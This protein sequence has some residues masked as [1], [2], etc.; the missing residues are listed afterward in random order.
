ME[1]GIANETE[2][3]TENANA[4]VTVTVTVTGIENVTATV[5][6]TAIRA[7]TTNATGTANVKETVLTVTVI[8]TA[9]GTETGRCV[10]L[11]TITVQTIMTHTPATTDTQSGTEI[12]TETTGLRSTR[13]MN[14]MDGMTDG[15]LAEAQEIMGTGV[16]MTMRR[17]METKMKMERKA[18]R[19]ANEAKI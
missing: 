2:T 7:G 12:A 11:G 14:E 10:A 3:E 9:N 1:I 5:T 8:A 18:G 16:G 13:V 19:N 17:L 4:N 6:R 15:E